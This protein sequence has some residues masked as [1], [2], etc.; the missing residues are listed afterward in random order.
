MD[1][2][3]GGGLGSVLTTTAGVALYNVFP[4]LESCGFKSAGPEYSAA[5]TAVIESINTNSVNAM[6]ALLIFNLLVILASL[7]YYY[8]SLLQ[9]S[10]I[11]MFC[12]SPVFTGAGS[13]K[14][15][16]FTCEATSSKIN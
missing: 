4:S 13:A 15:G 12:H 11:S 7:N 5:D 6:T 14:A 1:T 9:N 3:P 10:Y 8:L 16:V 2:C